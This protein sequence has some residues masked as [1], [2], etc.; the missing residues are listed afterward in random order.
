MCLH[1][2]ML[3]SILKKTVKTILQ[4]ALHTHLT[5]PRST[6]HILA[7]LFYKTQHLGIEPRPLYMLAQYSTN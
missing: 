4:S 3:Q 6:K 7:L 5:I 1:A 2:V